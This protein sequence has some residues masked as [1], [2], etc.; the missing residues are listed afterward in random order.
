MAVTSFKPR[1][2][3]LP[4]PKDSDTGGPALA[5]CAGQRCCLLQE[6][7]PCWAFLGHSRLTS[8]AELQA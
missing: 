6:G 8:L 4:C 7:W 5:T 3:L 1:N 2:A